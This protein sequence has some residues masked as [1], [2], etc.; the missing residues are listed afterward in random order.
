MHIFIFR[1]GK[2]SGDALPV[3]HRKCWVIILPYLAG[4]DGGFFI[5]EVFYPDEMYFFFNRF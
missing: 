5:F 2:L 1:M 3:V 4:T